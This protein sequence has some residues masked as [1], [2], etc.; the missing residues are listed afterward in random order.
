M[1]T[2]HRG[3]AKAPWGKIAARIAST[4][5]GTSRQMLDV[6]ERDS[7]ELQRV[8]FSFKHLYENLQIVSCYELQ[9]TNLVTEN[10]SVLVSCLVFQRNDT[11]CY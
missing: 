6:L 2:P 10:T 5:V 7:P 3:S 1:G 9:K 8:T 11:K 4:A